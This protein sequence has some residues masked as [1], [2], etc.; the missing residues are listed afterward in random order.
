MEDEAKLKIGVTLPCR[1]KFTFPPLRFLGSHYR[2]VASLQMELS[3]GICRIV[4]AKASLSLLAESRF[5][6]PR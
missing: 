1:Q 6:W 2:A 3:D 5:F 4:L